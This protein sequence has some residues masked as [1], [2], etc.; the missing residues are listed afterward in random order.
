MRQLFAPMT[1]LFLCAFALSAFGDETSVARKAIEI[2]IKKTIAATEK[3]EAVGMLAF[4]APDYT[5]VNRKKQTFGLKEMRGRVNRLVGAAKSIKVKAE[6]KKF[7]LKGNAATLTISEEAT[8]IAYNQ[9]RKRDSV[10]KTF[11][12]IEEVWSKAGGTWLRRRGTQLT[13][14]A[15]LDGQK[16]PE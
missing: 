4:Y 8:V 13:S 11:S 9:K 5:F 16:Q 6:I 12:T 10:L 14:T 7:T 1:V 15:T 2:D 3:K